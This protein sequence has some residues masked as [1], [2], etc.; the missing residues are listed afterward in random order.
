[1]NIERMD[2]EIFR[3]GIP[4]PFPMKYVYCYLM[5]NDSGYTMIDTGF[6]YEKAISAWEEAFCELN[7]TP[8]QI[9]TIIITHFHPD[10]SGLSGWMQKKTGAKVWMSSTDLKMLHLA[11]GEGVIQ[12]RE[13]EKLLSD[14]GVPSNLREEIHTN[15]LKIKNHVQPIADIQPITEKEIIL[16]S[17]VWKIIETPGHSEGH[18]C[19][20]QEEAKILITADMILDKITPNISLWPGGS[21]HPLNDY[22]ESLNRLKQLP[23]S[24]AWPGHGGIIYNVSQRI[25]ELIQHHQ[26]RLNKISVLASNKTGF[27]ITDKLFEERE[28]NGHQWRFAIAETLA[29]LEYLVDEKKIKN[30]QSEP[31]LYTN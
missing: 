6:H 13:I 1:M 15:L 26:H 14:H 19:F 17:R 30:V 5:K 22:L 29:H 25:E 28:L 3:I 9:H 31:I 7:I 23:I 16:D 21:K 10:H 8:S 4:I 2:E 20:Y 27:E 24:E 11:F 12:K 18:L